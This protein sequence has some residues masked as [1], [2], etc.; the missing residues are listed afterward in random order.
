MKKH[1]WAPLALAAAGFAGTAYSAEL[2]NLNGQS[3]GDLVG[4]WH[5]VNNQIPLGSGLGTLTA[6]FSGGSCTTGPGHVTQR[7]Q[8]FFCTAI[9]ELEGASTDLGGRLVLSDF[10]CDTVKCNPETQKCEIP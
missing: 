1:V 5:F 8:H 3:C 2:A 10:S 4:T 6:T 9:G 7:V